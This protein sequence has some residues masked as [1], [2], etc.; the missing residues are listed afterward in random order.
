MEK[1]KLSKNQILLYVL[2]IVY[3][4]I[5]YTFIIISEYINQ[6][7]VTNNLVYLKNKISLF[8][9]ILPIIMCIINFVIVFKIG[10]NENSKILLNCTILIK[11]SLI[12]LYIIG[13]LL[14]LIFLLLSFIPIPIMIFV[15]PFITI[16]LC[17]F[18]W[19]ILLGSSPFSIAYI[20]KS[21]SEKKHGKALSIIATI[22]QF[23]FVLDVFSIMF[24]TLK[25]KRWKKLTFTVLALLLILFL[26]GLIGI[27]SIVFSSYKK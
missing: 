10:K 19:L 1:N 12:P 13:Y 16:V 4:I 11:Y 7:S 6:L 26:L 20:K 15:G 18:G 25:E 21:Y 8:F 17:I 3:V 23:F 9:L 2:S 5:S 27:I 14:I 24:L 22:F